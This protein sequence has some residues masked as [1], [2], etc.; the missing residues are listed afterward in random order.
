MY[1]QQKMFDQLQIQPKM[2][3]NKELRM[4]RYEDKNKSKENVDASTNYYC[5][6]RIL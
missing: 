1:Q 2:Q 4:V 6:I 5:F 3:Q